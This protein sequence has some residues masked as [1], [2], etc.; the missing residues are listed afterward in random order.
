V[1]GTGGKKQACYLPQQRQPTRFSK[2]QA[3]KSQLVI[4]KTANA[5]TI[6]ASR[7]K[8]AASKNLG[9]SVH[10]I[11]QSIAPLRRECGGK[12]N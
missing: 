5:V 7:K 8:Q 9:N 6:Y 10:C 12:R 4:A 2:F 3:N 1:S 11:P